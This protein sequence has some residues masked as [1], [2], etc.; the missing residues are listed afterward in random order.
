MM[1]EGKENKAATALLIVVGLLGL[2]LVIAKG[3]DEEEKVPKVGGDS[4]GDD[5]ACEPMPNGVSKGVSLEAFEAS[6]LVRGT[7]H[8]MEHTTDP[9]IARRIAADHLAEDPAYYDKL[10]KAGL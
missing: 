2:G 7:L 6:Q 1:A 3:R 4:E 5:S 8:E 10:E 9:K